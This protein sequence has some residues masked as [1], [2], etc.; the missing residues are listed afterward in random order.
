MNMIRSINAKFKPVPMYEV[1]GVILAKNSR[2]D[3]MSAI[4]EMPRIMPPIEDKI[5]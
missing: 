3:A 4:N 1:N 2:I 5:P